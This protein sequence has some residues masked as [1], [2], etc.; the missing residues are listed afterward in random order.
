MLPCRLR[1]GQWWRLGQWSLDL[2]ENS[3]SATCQPR[4]FSNFVPQFPY[5][6]GDLRMTQIRTCRTVSQWHYVVPCVFPMSGMLLVVGSAP[7]H[8]LSTEMT[9]GIMG[10]M[11]LPQSGTTA[12]VWQ[13]LIMYPEGQG[14]PESGPGERQLVFT[15]PCSL[16]DQFTYLPSAL[17]EKHIYHPYLLVCVNV[18]A[19]QCIRVCMCMEANVWGICIN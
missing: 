5:Y 9:P 13:P 10:C 17:W 7:V 2:R 11:S 3:A 4:D 16:Q 1:L 18:Y 19:C 6:R 8:L 15:G 14:G 12:V